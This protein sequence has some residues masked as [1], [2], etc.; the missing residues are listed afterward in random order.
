V[1]DCGLLIF[2]Y[3]YED[4]GFKGFLQDESWGAAAFASGFLAPD[5]LGFRI[6]SEFGIK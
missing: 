3:V 2:G 4:V 5:R 1:L 6:Y